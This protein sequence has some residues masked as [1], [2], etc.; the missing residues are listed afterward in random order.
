MLLYEGGQLKTEAVAVY[1]GLG[2][3]MGGRQENLDKA[4]DLISQRLRVGKVSSIYDTD[5]IGNTDQPRFLNMVC[6]AYTRLTAE[7]LLAL[8]HSLRR[9]IGT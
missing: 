5:A 6:Q 2:S 1:L 7:A 3:N 9:R 8:G 4:L